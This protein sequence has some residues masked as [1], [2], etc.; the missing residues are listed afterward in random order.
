MDPVNL[1]VAINLFVSMTANW[2]GAQKG[3]KTSITKVVDR[4]DTF[5]QKYPP[6][7]AMIILI[8]I[9]ASIF[10]LGTLGDIYKQEHHTL[11]I[12]GLGLF[13]VFS[14]IQVAAY[15]SLGKSY[16]QDIVIL[17]D[18][19]LCTSGLYKFIRHPQYISQ[20]L[21]DLG[22]GI[23]LMSF[24]VVPIV[25]IFELPLFVLRARA[26]EKLLSKHFKNEFADYKKKSGFIFP[27]IG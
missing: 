11:R 16:A 2:G 27:F 7:V 25:I 1:L 23:A 21:S 5:L 22:A 13:V 17:K 9:I 10:E 14:W 4:P 24:T 12:V 19:K 26:E 6:N 3:L 8:L 15:K 18:H 20:F